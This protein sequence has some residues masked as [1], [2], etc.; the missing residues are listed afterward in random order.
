MDD[1]TARGHINDLVSVD[2]G[3]DASTF[4]TNNFDKCRIHGFQARVVLFL[5]W[6]AGF[7]NLRDGNIMRGSFCYRIDHY[8]LITALSIGYMRQ[9]W[10][11]HDDI[12]YLDH[13]ETLEC[14]GCTELSPKIFKLHL[15]KLTLYIQSLET[16]DNLPDLPTISEL[17]VRDIEGSIYNVFPWITQM[18]PNIHTLD[19]SGMKPDQLQFF[20]D[21]MVAA[22]SSMK[23]A[24]K[25][26]VIRGC[27]MDSAEL[28]TLLLDVLASFRELRKLDITLSERT[29]FA[30]IAER[31]NGSSFEATSR[32]RIMNFH[33]PYSSYRFWA[34]EGDILILA[35]YFKELCHIN[36]IIPLNE[37]II[38]QLAENK[39]RL[40]I[41]KL[42][43][44]QVGRATVGGNRIPTTLLPIALGMTNDWCEKFGKQGFPKHQ[45]ER[46]Q[47]NAIFHFLQNMPETAALTPY[48]TVKFS[49]EESTAETEEST[50]G[51]LSETLG[52]NIAGDAEDDLPQ[53]PTK[54]RRRV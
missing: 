30:S 53:L 38:N 13:L 33:G 40:S 47:Q 12:E 10:V 26:L 44:N 19:L 34:G 39:V 32:L 2:E 36:G 45:I 23:N 50:A 16:L 8:G 1:H 27:A 15:K 31:I 28:E 9:T 21:A 51:T 7:L 14:A 17:E 54:R 11:L 6:K 22:N 25:N 4:F 42:F 52:G 5:L 20:F 29:S 35:V 49:A 24:L 43:S 48:P 3:K 41:G 46:V 18:L 37:A